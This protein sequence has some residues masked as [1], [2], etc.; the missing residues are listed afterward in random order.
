MQKTHDNLHPKDLFESK[1]QIP[2]CVFNY[3]GVI[4]KVY[5][6]AIN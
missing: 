4:C 2:V 3:E 1:Y 6:D 5:G